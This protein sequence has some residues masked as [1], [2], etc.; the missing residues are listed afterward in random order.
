MNNWQP[1]FV[2]SVDL[3][4]HL[5]KSYFRYDDKEKQISKIVFDDFAN[6]IWCGDTYGRVSSYDIN[7][8]LY[9]RCTSHIGAIPVNDILIRKEG[10]ISLCDDSIH[11]SNRRGVTISS[12][13][14]MELSVLTGLKTMC[15]NSNDSQ[16]SIYCAGN[17]TNTGIISIDLNK[18]CLSS[19]IDYNPKVKLLCTSNKIISIGKQS[20]SID[21]LDP[22]SN[23]IIKSF[24][25]HSATISAMDSR[26]YTLTTVGKS[27][28]FN[29]TYADPFVN[30]YDLR[31]MRQLPPISFSKGTSMGSGGADFVRLHPVLPTIMTV[32]S[33]QGSFDF[34]DLSNPILRTQYVH[35]CKSIKA[36][37]LSPNGDHIAFLN[38]DNTLNLWSRSGGSTNCTNKPEPLEYPEYINDGVNSGL[39]SIDNFDY[40]LSSVGMPYYNEKLLSAWPQVIFHSNGTIPKAIDSNSLQSPK[41]KNPTLNSRTSST[42]T[43]NSHLASKQYPL[44]RYN[45]SKYGHGNVA[46]TY[47]SLSEIRKKQNTKST[48]ANKATT[49]GNGNGS[50]SDELSDILRVKPERDNEIPPAYTK[51]QLTHGKYGSD[52]F[53]FKAFNQTKYSGLDT[54]LDHPYINPIVQLYRFVPEIF[55]FIVGCL[56]YENF[57]PNSILTELG[58]LYDM[59]QRS[60]GRVCL[61]SNLQATLD[62]IEENN[63]FKSTGFTSSKQSKKSNIE[64]NYQTINDTPMNKKT[65]VGSNENLMTSTIQN[66]NEFLLDHLMTDELQRNIHSITLEEAFGFHLETNISSSCLHYEKNTSIVPTLTV[67]SPI[68]NNLKHNVR[69]LNNQTILPYIESSMKRTALMQST[70]EVCNKQELVEYE[71]IIKNL[72]P[73]L[74]L[75]LLLSDFEWGIAKTVK[76]WLTL[77]FHATISKDK[78]VLKN[79]PGE[80]KTSNPIF[81]YELS[82]YIAR[83]TDTNGE[84]RLVTYSRAFDANSKR[85]KW[86]MFNDYLVVEVEEEEA[87]NISYW[88]K[89]I[90]TVIYCDSEEIRKPFLS[91][92]S[93]PINYNILYRDHFAN[94]IRKDVIKQYTLLNKD[95]DKDVPKPGTLVAIDA[96]FV[97]LNEEISEIDCKGNKTIIKPKK[98]ALARVSILRGDEG[99]KFGEP[100]V[101]DYIVNN[102][103][104]ENYVTKYSGIE[105]GDLDIKYSSKQLVNR[106]VTYRKIWLLMQMGCVF[107]GH[108]LNNDFKQI[109]INIPNNQIRD[110]S[111]YFLQGKRYL[112]LRYLAFAILDSN[113][114]EGNHD[115][116]E[117]AFTALVLYK[118]YLSLKENNTL[119]HVLDVI[120]EEGRI[121]NFKVPELTR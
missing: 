35:P 81:K 99:D 41:V 104:I 56:K 49:S 83:I 13:T 109:N 114:Q 98:T 51:L 87:L 116:I 19:M 11:I 86:Y 100:F 59:M 29:N 10:I 16:N 47:V 33:D 88:W 4:E 67:C 48:F 32:A 54:D 80:L 91:V 50:Q 68:K 1:S 69:K 101:D 46:E 44:L 3:T 106:N 23:H 84:S 12:I 57:S 77:E 78:A 5:K 45:K 73:V 118:K 93:Y 43:A 71:S 92:D 89:T 34:V 120:Y 7:S 58:Y 39:T 72:P 20:G 30:V 111:I 119:N 62:I 102:D 17:N 94:G 90:E 2:N 26:D 42:Q 61:T 36:M 55:N 25:G 97:V 63:S 96:E 75:N 22:N 38:S 74:S 40:P 76:D 108:G 60:E 15:F 18:N 79:H 52:N 21:L 64:I 66:F 53:D 27:K 121:T 115:S 9:T 113:I 14:S 31:I 107:V 85:F 24:A 70:C 95:D 37:E 28:R 8:Q 105:P 103:R 110:T 6:L 82:G 65:S 112:S 117:D